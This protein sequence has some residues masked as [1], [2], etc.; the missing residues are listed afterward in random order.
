M[1]SLMMTLSL[2]FA[3]LLF[4]DVENVIG[5]AYHQTL[6]NSNPEL[7]YI[8]K[9][10]Y[11]GTQ[12]KVL[13]ENGRAGEFA[14]KSLDYSLGYSTPNLTFSNTLCQESYN[15]THVDEQPIHQDETTLAIK[16]KNVC[17]DERF[18]K[19]LTIS[20]PYVI[21]AG[22][23]FYIR[24]NLHRINNEN[25]LFFYAL[26]SRASSVKL[27]AKSQPC[28]DIKQRFT[29]LI[30]TLPEANNNLDQWQQCLS[31]RPKSWVLA[32]FFPTM[33][34]AYSSDKKLKLFAGKSN[35]G[36]AEGDYKNVFIVYNNVD[37]K[38]KDST[39]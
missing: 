5:Y 22:F 8:E 30:A 37:D 20:H 10:R 23:D 1:K 38:A 33:H 12:H 6:K 9:H 35:I 15:I 16:Y 14:K 27:L 32:Q 39:F 31:I 18:D 2:G 34:L 28:D 4:A 26:P 19:T 36:D 3:P 17:D 11:D 24:E 13:Y 29:A 25:L 7:L 21:D